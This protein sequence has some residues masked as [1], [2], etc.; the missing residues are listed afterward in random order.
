M[1]VKRHTWSD[2]K[3]HTKPEIRTQ[4]E[5]KGCRLSDGLRSE[6]ELPKPHS[7]GVGRGECKPATTEGDER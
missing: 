2:I 5:A 4:I 3:A 6:P 7:K 1:S